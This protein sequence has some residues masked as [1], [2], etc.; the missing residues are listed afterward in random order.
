MQFDPVI[1]DMSRFPRVDV[2]LLHPVA[3]N[4]PAPDAGD[5]G[6]AVRAALARCALPRVTPGMRIALGVGSRGIHGLPG[7]V[8]AAVDALRASGGQPFIIPAMGSHGG[9]TGEGQRAVLRDLGVTEA[10]AGCPIVS[11]MDTVALGEVN[12]APAR[13]DRNA[14]EA[15]ATLII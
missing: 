3:F 1:R 11:S 5:I 13:M 4:W 14:Y 12:G 15:D 9:A 10:S 8:R 7:I 2:P 6:A